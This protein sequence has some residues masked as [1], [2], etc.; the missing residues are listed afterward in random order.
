MQSL[1]AHQVLSVWERGVHLDP[2]GR[3]LLLLAECYP[4]RKLS[5]LAAL[6]L[7][8]RD[9]LLLHL[10]RGILGPRLSGFGRCQS[11]D[12]QVQF[13]LDIDEVFQSAP[14]GDPFVFP[15]E[16][17]IEV[18]GIELRFRLPDSNDL[19]SI[20]DCVET[21]KAA[22]LLLERCV[23]RA[24]GSSQNDSA[25]ELSDEVGVVIAHEVGQLDPLAEIR[26][27]LRCPECEESWPLVLDVAT[28]VWSEI[29]LLAKGLLH[30]VH[31]LA[32]AYA[33]REEDILAMSARRRRVYLGMVS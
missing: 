14:E 31:A 20:A 29:V 11:C 28:F 1:S 30:E 24:E 33:W 10:R 15:A 26:L 7:G 27:N 19:T 21:D 22:R 4:E 18:S 17:S 8:R 16:H 12:E 13:A 25:E 23:S 3:A 6:P 32:R 5:Q 2:V 9:L